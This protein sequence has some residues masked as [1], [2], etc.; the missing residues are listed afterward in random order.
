M[1][2]FFSPKSKAKA[3]ISKTRKHKSTGKQL[4]D[5]IEE[6]TGYD[7]HG[8]AICRH[9]S[10]RIVFAEGALLGEQVKLRPTTYTDKVIQADVLSVLESSPQRIAEKCQHFDICG[11]CQLQYMDSEQQVTVK[12]SALDQLMSK[13]LGLV[14]LPW[15]QAL[16]PNKWQY[17]RTARLVF[18]HEKNK[19]LVLG[20]RQAKSKQIINVE[21]C[22]ILVP[23]LTD[24]VQKIKPVC[25]SLS[26]KN[27][28]THLQLFS[29]DSGVTAIVRTTNELSDE[30]KNSL[31]TFAKDEQ[32]N[33]YVET[34]KNQYQP[35]FVTDKQAGHLPYLEYRL[36]DIKLQFLP[37][38]FIQINAQVNEAM[39]HQALNWLELNENDTVLDLFS[40]IGNFTLPLAQKVA[41]VM[42][43]EGVNAMVQRLKHNATLNNLT[44]INAYQADLSK[45]D[46][47]SKPQWLKSIDKLVLDPARDGAFSV[48]KNIKVLN[49]KQILYVSCNPATM[50]RDIIE[51]VDADYNLTKVSLLNMFPQTS[52]VEAMALLEKV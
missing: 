40:G 16:S 48:V 17:R 26:Q 50:I 46:D 28:L 9:D 32:V 19:P 25:E 30:D 15:Q 29:V 6:V 11:G 3:R 34:E 12:Q 24:L 18:W 39:I 43:V 22:P 49:P 31:M 33:F 41:K 47:K 13:Q 21:H 8:K 10:G 42:A 52:H 5:F 2:Q 35:I 7:H 23:E 45:I 51:L 38:D 1:A 37:Q 36:Q 4:P 44:N 20:F 14:E 27:V